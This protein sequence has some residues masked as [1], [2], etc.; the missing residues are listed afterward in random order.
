M[1]FLQHSFEGLA[2]GKITVWLI[3][4]LTTYKVPPISLRVLLQGLLLP[5]SLYMSK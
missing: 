3:I 4:A 1:D 5:L 2:E